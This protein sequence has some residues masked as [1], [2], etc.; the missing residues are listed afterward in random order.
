MAE[1]VLTVKDVA[2]RLRC[3]KWLVY[4]L[5]RKGELS[6]FRAGTNLRFLPADLDDYVRRTSF[7]ARATPPPAEMT[8]PRHR[9]SGRPDV[10]AAYRKLV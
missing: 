1:V 4:E 8:P 3:S 10:R 2:S 9:K 7:R 6:G 5:V